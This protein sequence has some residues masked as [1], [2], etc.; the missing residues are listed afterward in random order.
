ML[1][2]ALAALFLLAAD[3]FALLR[4]G[5]SYAVD[6]GTFRDKYFLSNVNY[7]EEADGVTYRWS[8]GSP[9][10][11][12]DQIGVSSAIAL[13]MGVGGRPEPANVQVLADGRPLVAFT[14]PTTPRRYTLLLPPQLAEQ[15]QITF[16]TDTFNPPGDARRLGLKL[17]C[18]K[19]QMFWSSA[20]LPMP[21]H[22]G[23]QLLALVLAQLTLIRLGWGWRAQGLVLLAAASGLAFA[24]GFELLLAHSWLP[25][26]AVA[27]GALALLTWL[28][29]P[30]LER[31]FG[32]LIE[33]RE[34]RILWAMMLLFCLIRMIPIFYPTFGGQDLG[35]NITR[36]VRVIVGQLYI[37]A[38]TGEF[39]RGLTIYPPGPYIGLQPLG[40]LTLDLGSIL[41]GSLALMDG[42]TALAVA[43]LARVL[44]ANRTA[45]RL[46]LV[47]YG[48][49]IA[50]FGGLAYSFSAQVYGQ[51][52]TTPMALAILLAERPPRPRSWVIA[53]LLMMF[54]TMTHIGVAIIN[55][56]W[57]GLL[58]LVL[59]VA[60]RR[61]L[62]GPAAVPEVQRRTL[63]GWLIAGISAAIAYAFL[64]VEIVAET[65]SHAAAK[66]LPDAADEFLPGFSELLVRGLRLG[67]SDIGLLLIPIGLW[68]IVRAQPD[69]RRLALP[70]A[71]VLTW[72]FFFIVELLLDVQ[73]RY[74]YFAVP[75]AMVAIA[76]AL[77][78]LGRFGRRGQLIGWA[79]T[80]WIILPQIWLWLTVTF[81]DGKM[82]MTPLT[83]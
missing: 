48:G 37:I 1:V 58:L 26:I 49:N 10:L 56:A 36:L 47:L 66:V 63:W 70:V 21:Q 14:A 24:L 62:F 5:G 25:R 52:F 78:E 4:F 65:L 34:L 33:P 50:A 46:A 18:F 20:P 68:L 41:Q 60:H 55:F 23:M 3:S 15:P 81:G 74:F 64:Y 79:L 38:L 43:L 51:W 32:H 45:V 30:L 22:Y 57:V 17:D 71:W 16:R 80:L 67:Y 77:G 75:L 39:S 61:E 76:V 42:T 27:V 13:T 8:E 6:I 12:F 59:L 11:S 29:L 9:R 44:G 35:R 53:M 19:V 2:L 7:Q 82:P 83:H 72:I 31:H 28:V 73:V 54:G 69:L 40:T